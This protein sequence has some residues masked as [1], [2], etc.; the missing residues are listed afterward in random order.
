[1]TVPFSIIVAVDANFGIGKDGVLPWHL[2]SD[3]KRVKEITTKTTAADKRNVVIMGRKTW[4]SLPERFKPLPDRIN[5]VLSRN[6]ELTLPSDVLKENSLEGAF[7]LLEK[8][9]KNFYEKVF[10][11]GGAKVFN[12]CMRLPNCEN[13]YL[14]RIH[15]QFDCDTFFPKDLSAFQKISETPPLTEKDLPYSFEEYVRK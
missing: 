1:M 4:E 10:V 6:E 11:F 14:T 2:S 5:L 9:Y 3:L 13:I 15:K 7:E 8:K 12:E